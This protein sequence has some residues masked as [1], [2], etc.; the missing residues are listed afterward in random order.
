VLETTVEMDF[1]KNRTPI[2]TVEMAIL[3]FR[4]PISTLEISP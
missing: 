1:L 4:K 3:K 2:S